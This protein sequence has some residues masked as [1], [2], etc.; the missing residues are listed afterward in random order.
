MPLVRMLPGHQITPPGHIAE[1]ATPVVFVSILRSAG[2]GLARCRLL[3][4]VA[5]L[6][7]VLAMVCGL[8][9]TRRPVW[10][11]VWHSPLQSC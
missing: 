2:D 11:A 7:D 1:M 4:C 6:A 8:P 10:Y 5:C 9:T 3:T